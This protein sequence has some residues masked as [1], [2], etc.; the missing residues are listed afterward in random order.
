MG[1]YLQGLNETLVMV[2]LSSFFSI[3]IG[4]PLGIVLVLTHP[5]GIVPR[6]KLYRI[7]DVIINLFRSFPFIILIVVFRPLSELLTGR[8][9]GTPAMTVSLTLSAIP[10]IA[11]I[12][13]TSI[14]EVGTGVIE[15]A[16][17]MGTSIPKLIT[18]VLVPESLPALIKGMTT[19]VINIIG[20]SAMAGVVGGGGL[21]DLAIRWGL[22]NRHTEK[23]VIA[24][25]MIVA[26]VQIVQLL[27]NALSRAIDHR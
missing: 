2:G 20:Y 1:D 25:L 15:A 4:L 16:L 13:E 11:R 27:G 7:M 18:R 22:Y 24:V 19:T 6:P 5:D 3:A 14:N 26:L 21:G 8:S 17:A 10:F 23:L 9:S 12:M